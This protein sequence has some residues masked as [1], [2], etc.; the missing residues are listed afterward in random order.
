[1]N[2]CFYL[3][4]IQHLQQILARENI[5]KASFFSQQRYLDLINLSLSVRTLPKVGTDE[6]CQIF[7]QALIYILGQ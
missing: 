4:K 7:I 5:C 2:P 3:N 6:S 1:M